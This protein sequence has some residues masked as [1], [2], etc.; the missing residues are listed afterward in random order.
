MKDDVTVVPVDKLIIVDKQPLV[1]EF[2]ADPNL[3]ALQ[4]HGGKGELEFND[5]TIN[6]KFAEEGYAKYVEPFVTLWEHENDAREKA[7]QEQLAT[8][9]T[10]Q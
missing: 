5:G 7:L 2:W 3:H 8:E 6:E 10:T 9:E 1:F 4:W